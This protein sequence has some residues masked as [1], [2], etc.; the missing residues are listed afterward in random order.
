[1]EEGEGRGREG[2]IKE[3]GG[4]EGG[5]R[6]RKWKGGEGGRKPT[7]D[8]IGVG[9]LNSDLRMRVSSSSSKPK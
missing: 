2:K 9:W 8:W 4:R 7:W 5:G 1:M 3:E 6:G